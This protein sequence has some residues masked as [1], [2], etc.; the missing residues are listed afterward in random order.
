VRKTILA[1]TAGVGLMFAGLTPAMAV[2]AG[3]GAGA[4]DNGNHAGI[5]DVGWGRCG[6]HNRRCGPRVGITAPGVG[7]YVGGDRHHYHHGWNHHWH[8]HHHHRHW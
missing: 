8:H 5:T 1:L 3:T 7:V 4:L 2:P 6:W